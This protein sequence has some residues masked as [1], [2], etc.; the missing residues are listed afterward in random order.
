MAQGAGEKKHEATDYRR[1]RAREEGNVPKSQ[2][3]GSAVLLLVGVILLDNYGGQIGVA[4]IQLITDL[5]GS[6]PIIVSSSR[7]ETSLLLRQVIRAGIS[8]LPLMAGLVATS[9]VVHFSQVGPMWLPQKL[10][11]DIQRID[12][13]QGTKRLFSITNV[14]R[15]G[16][17]LLK[18][19]LV[20]GIL[21][22]GVWSRW[23]EILALGSADL[24]TVGKF[25]WSTMMVLCRNV[26]IALVALAFLD[27]VFQRWKYEQDLRMTDEELREEY[28][29]T[30]V[31][32]HT[33]SRRRRVQRELAQQRLAVDVPKADVV[34]TNPTELAIA[35]KY[36]PKTMK[37]PIVLA[38]GAD[39]VAAKIRRIALENGIPIVERK[40]LAQALFKQVDIGKPI[41]TSEYAA[42]A[43]VLKYVYEVKGLSMDELTETLKETKRRTAG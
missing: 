39:L 9:L 23:N 30:Q 20:G 4:L 38:K 26:A 5:E 21:L 8:V 15:L 18:I 7:D 24:S 2:D 6:V 27:L 10:A 3:L 34:V 13:I 43:E 25:L 36:D 32:P 41:P 28:K 14:T 35:L 40:P 31:D 33:K 12:P 37:A 19:M 16:F 42:V 29:M 1:W 17:G 22:L 11:F